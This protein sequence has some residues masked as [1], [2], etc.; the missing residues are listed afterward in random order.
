MSGEIS[1]LGERFTQNLGNLNFKLDVLFEFC[2]YFIFAFVRYYKKFITDSNLYVL[3]MV[4]R[5]QQPLS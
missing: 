2:K 5:I 1:A 3:E 4:L